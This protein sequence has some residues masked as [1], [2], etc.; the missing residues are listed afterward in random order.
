MLLLFL[1]MLSWLLLWLW[2]MLWGRGG[3]LVLVWVGPGGGV[4]RRGGEW[5]GL[6]EVW[7]RG[8]GGGGQGAVGGWVWRPLLLLEAAQLEVEEFV[9]R[10]GGGGWGGAGI[11]VTLRMH[12]HDKTRSHITD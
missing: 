8:A 4:V 5:G 12:R 1:C 2:L 9:G 7:A 6:D 10:R 11:L 3:V